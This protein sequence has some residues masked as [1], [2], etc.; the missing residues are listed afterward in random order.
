M[1]EFTIALGI[2]LLV[3]S[4]QAQLSQRSQADQAPQPPPR[5][6]GPPDSLAA[7]APTGLIVGSNNYFS[8]IVRDLDKA[9]AFYRDGLG[10]EPQGA[11]GDASNNAALRDMFGLPNAKLRWQITRTAA[12][13]GGVEIVEI[14]GVGGKPL[15]RNF[16]DPAR[17]R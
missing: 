6:Q 4:A 16:Q 7:P 9:V 3:G 17:T 2:A 5:L 8:P 11:Q 14:S 13:R 15:E 1:K 10:L 12:L